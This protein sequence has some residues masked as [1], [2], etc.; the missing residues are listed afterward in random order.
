M[1]MP[2]CRFRGGGPPRSPRA[3]PHPPPLSSPAVGQPG[4]PACVLTRARACRAP[5][6]PSQCTP[7]PSPTIEL[8]QLATRSHPCPTVA[9]HTS[10]PRTAPMAKPSRPCTAP[11]PC[12]PWTGRRAIKQAAPSSNSP[13]PHHPSHLPYHTTSS[14]PPGG[15]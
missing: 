5:P 4:A 6:K 13:T 1:A 7:R 11:A 3:A 10:R 9:R 15:R 12:P 14:T 8:A 2:P